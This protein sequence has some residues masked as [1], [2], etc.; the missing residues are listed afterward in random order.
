ME[1]TLSNIPSRALCAALM[2]WVSGAMAQAFP[3]K[4]VR[5]IIANAPGIANDAIARGMSQFLGP[6]TGQPFIVENRVGADGAIGMEACAKSAP[7]GH[8]I[9]IAAQ[10]AIVVNA[11]L[12]LKLPNDSARDFVPVV[13]V[14]YFDSG[15]VVS[16]AVPVKNFQELQELA[17]AKPNSVSW[18][19]FGFNSSGYMYS[20]W[21]RKSRAVPFYVVPYKAPPQMIQALI[22]G[23]VQAGVTSIGSV[24][25]QISSGKLRVLAVTSD[26]RQTALP[27][28]PTFAELGIKLPLRTWYGMLAP[29]GTPRAAIQWLNTEFSR[30]ATDPEFKSKFLESNGV[31]FVPNTPEQFAAMIRANRE[32]FIDLVNFLGL[33]PE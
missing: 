8:T 33:K 3:S 16:A 5:I 30:L 6:K 21:L 4:P 23:E 24:A 28:V 7:D 19:I 29:T 31:A 20:E 26:E 18:G 13:H 15:L 25:T 12:K 11:L 1:S 2:V 10:G 27:D 32:G 14:G 9:C 22:A 17:K